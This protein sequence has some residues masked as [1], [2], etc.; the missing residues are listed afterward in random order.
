MTEIHYPVKNVQLYSHF[1]CLPD[2]SE[3]ALQHKSA[4]PSEVIRSRM[5]HDTREKNKGAM[6][7]SELIVI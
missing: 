7:T 1:M 4:S 5:Y 2:Q 6:T 3:Y